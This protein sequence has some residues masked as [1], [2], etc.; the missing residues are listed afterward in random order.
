MLGYLGMIFFQ[1]ETIL[2]I[3]P[4]PAELEVTQV[5]GEPVNET[6][7][8]SCVHCINP[9]VKKLRGLG[10]Y[11]TTAF[12]HKDFLSINQPNTSSGFT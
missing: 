2:P 5:V 3:V 4:A 11:L 8:A 12:K 7:K 9:L 1:R 6:V 10:E